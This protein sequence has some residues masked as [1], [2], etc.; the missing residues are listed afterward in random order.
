MILYL[1]SP[2]PAFEQHLAA[3]RQLHAD[4]QLVL[5][6]AEQA[7]A[8]RIAQAAFG[9]AAAALVFDRDVDSDGHFIAATLLLVRSDAGGLLWFNEDYAYDYPGAE[10]ISDDR[11]RPKVQIDHLVQHTIETHLANA[12]DAADD[13]IEAMDNEHDDLLR[14]SAPQKNLL[15]LDVTA[16]LADRTPTQ[17]R[18]YDGSNGPQRG[19]LDART[20]DI[21]CRLLHDVITHV[22]T[23]ARDPESILSTLAGDESRV[24]VERAELPLL[25]S[26]IAVLDPRT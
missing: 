23:P 8:A 15:R 14:V 25:A 10:D 4:A 12:Y 21:L 13:V 20:R 16:A 24:R 18:A 26:A 22:F 19:L 7:A 9:S 2:D 11:G 5:A 1:P 6:R 3:A 17:H